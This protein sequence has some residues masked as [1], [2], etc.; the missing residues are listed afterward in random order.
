MTST[1][2]GAQTF[3]SAQRTSVEL[4]RSTRSV[5]R[6][7][8]SVADTMGAAVRD[9]A[10]AV[11]GVGDVAASM[12]RDAGKATINLPR[13]LYEMARNTPRRLNNGFEELTLRGQHLASRIRRDPDVRSAV[14]RTTAAGRETREAVDSLRHA[15]QAQAR[16]VRT[17]SRR[18]GLRTRA[19]RYEAMTLEELHELAG[20]RGIGG[21]SSMNKR[22]LI[23][24]LRR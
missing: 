24:A 5:A 10:Y 11:L 7:L 20:Q 14:R 17:A 1:S 8:R 12:A 23:R 6:T 9:G 21:R 22:Q 15:A 3:R 16:G 13:R 19:R 2:T 18:I 4:E